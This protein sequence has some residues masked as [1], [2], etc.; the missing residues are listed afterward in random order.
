MAHTYSPKQ[1]GAL[2]GKTVATL[3]RWDREG[4]LRGH[5]SPTNRRYYTQDQYLAYIG[6]LA[7]P[8][9]RVVLDA[10]VSTRSQRPDLLNQG[11]A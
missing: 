1:F 8:E 3:Q 2:I 11:A 6:V 9:G 5:R 4:F 10:R 7:K